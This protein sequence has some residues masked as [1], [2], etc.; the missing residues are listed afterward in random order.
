[1]RGDLLEKK[2]LASANQSVKNRMRQITKNFLGTNVSIHVKCPAWPV[3]MTAVAA[4][5]T[6]V[7]NILY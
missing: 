7:M 2:M 1:M 6:E 5:D 3:V 4:I